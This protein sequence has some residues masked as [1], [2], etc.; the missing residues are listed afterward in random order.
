MKTRAMLTVHIGLPKTATTLLQQVL[1]SHHQGVDYLGKYPKRVLG[2]S[3]DDRRS[4]DRLMRA[5]HQCSLGGP[6]LSE[7]ADRIRERIGRSQEAGR[8]PLWSSEGICSGAPPNREFRARS[9]A[10]LVGRYRT[11]IVLRE[12]IS[13]VKSMY[14]QK[15]KEAQYRRRRD[16][17]MSRRFFEFE[18]WLEENWRNGP[19]RA[20]MNLDYARTIE[21]FAKNSGG[22]E[23][24]VFL[25]EKLVSQ[26]SEFIS[27]ICNFLGIDPDE[28]IALTSNQ[29]RNPRLSQNQFLRMRR[30]Y[31]SFPKRVALSLAT[32]RFR[33][34]LFGLGSPD[35]DSGPAEV[36]I[37]EAWRDRLCDF[38]REGN[39]RL[40][41]E[42]GLP[43]VDFGY[44][45]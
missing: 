32:R 10:A 15:L 35:P 9:L 44:P 40:I 20:L 31:S 1:F 2:H 3:R 7:C 36:A 11:L 6:G 21:L 30:I 18:E 12:P 39:Q 29:T 17:L 43:L 34:R 14:L 25:F 5:V 24:G 28:G 4:F 27:E 33:R 38:V 41:R 16:R 23:V 8:V 42:R 45:V 19:F 13:F 26:P 37:P 22:G